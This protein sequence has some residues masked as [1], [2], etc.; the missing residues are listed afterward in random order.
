MLKLKRIT[1]EATTRLTKNVKQALADYEKNA[2]TCY[3]GSDRSDFISAPKLTKDQ[4]R[5]IQDAFNNQD[6]SLCMDVVDELNSTLKAINVKREAANEVERRLEDAWKA[7]LQQVKSI[8]P[9]AMGLDDDRDWVPVDEAAVPVFNDEF[10][11]DRSIEAIQN[12]VD[13]ILDNLS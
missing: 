12:L 7:F 8:A 3:Q 4:F 1:D 2:G 6:I 11:Y 10:F 13:F 9:A 5:S